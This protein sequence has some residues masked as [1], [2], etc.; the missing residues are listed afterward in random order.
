MLT[1]NSRQLLPS[2]AD[3]DGSPVKKKG[4]RGMSTRKRAVARLSRPRDLA[5]K[6]R[7]VD[8]IGEDVDEIF[9]QSIGRYGEVAI[10]IMKKRVREEDKITHNKC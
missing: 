8:V 9:L 7:F 4:P 10:E 1:D 6:C 5:L 2:T 3:L